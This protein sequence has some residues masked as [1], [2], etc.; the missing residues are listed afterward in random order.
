[1]AAVQPGVNDCASRELRR[2]KKRWQ[3]SSARN[4]AVRM[5]ASSQSSP[6]PS[7]NAAPPA[8]RAR[9]ST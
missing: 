5:L 1:M 6:F 7:E 8:S 2:W 4:I 9:V 3:G